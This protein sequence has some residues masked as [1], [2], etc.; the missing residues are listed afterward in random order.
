MHG[1]ETKQA[2]M[3]SLLSPEQ[4]VPPARSEARFIPAPHEV[5]S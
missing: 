1:T 5:R 2:T 4:R 3:L